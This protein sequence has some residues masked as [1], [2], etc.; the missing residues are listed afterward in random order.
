MFVLLLLKF[1]LKQVHVLEETV[2]WLDEKGSRRSSVVKRPFIERWGIG[3]IS[4]GGPTEQYLFQSM[5]HNLSHKGRSMRQL[6]WSLL[7]DRRYITVN[8]M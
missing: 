8:K 7:Y 3:S 2:E 5:S 6:V 1:T 4:H